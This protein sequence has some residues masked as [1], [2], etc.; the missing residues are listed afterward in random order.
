MRDWRNT[1]GSLELLPFF[2]KWAS[3]NLEV[4]SEFL[5]SFPLRY[6]A[7][8]GFLA[9]AHAAADS[10]GTILPGESEW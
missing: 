5:T 2:D 6:L 9:R 4:D 8:Y 1:P 3:T 10:R 7:T